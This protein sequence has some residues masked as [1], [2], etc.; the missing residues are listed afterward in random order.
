VPTF[1][2]E[3]R[4]S[5]TVTCIKKQR[6]LG[7]KGPIMS[8]SATYAAVVYDPTRIIIEKLVKLH[9]DAVFLTLFDNSL[10]VG[11]RV[12]LY[13][14]Q[15]DPIAFSDSIMAAR[16][17]KLD[18]LRQSKVAIIVVDDLRGLEFFLSALSLLI[19]G[20]LNYVQVVSEL[21]ID[22][23]F[24]STTPSELSMIQELKAASK[25]IVT[26]QLQMIPADALCR[27]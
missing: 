26:A 20:E 14:S 6:T 27:D 2:L 5:Q 19:A 9:R 18:F 25:I 24:A 22:N 23:L 13:S 12:H 16:F 17:A 7:T 21:E 8:A 15:G 4:H 1:L 3:T 11:D 10:G